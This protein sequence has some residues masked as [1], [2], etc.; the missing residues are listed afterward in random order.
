MLRAWLARMLGS[1]S[2]R[3]RHSYQSAESRAHLG[4]ELARSLVG[5]E[6]ATPLRRAVVPQMG[7]TSPR[8]ALGQRDVCRGASKW[9]CG[10]RGPGTAAQ[11]SD[12]YY[13]ANVL[14]P[15]GYSLDG[16]GVG[17]VWKIGHPISVRHNDSSRVSEGPTR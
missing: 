11:F 16:Y 13:A 2:H 3:D 17:R 14:D 8:P 4:D 6:V 5:G 15:D 12:R 10:Q 7:V 9:R 1:A